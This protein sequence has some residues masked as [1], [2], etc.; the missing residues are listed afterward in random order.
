M[1]GSRL[2]QMVL[3]LIPNL[4]LGLLSVCSKWPYD[5]IGHNKDIMST[6]GGDCD[7]PY[8]IR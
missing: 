6:L 8:Q 7:I 4:G 3:E 1:I 2:L 5:P